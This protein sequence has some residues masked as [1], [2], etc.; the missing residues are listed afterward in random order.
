[1]RRREKKPRHVCRV[2]KKDEDDS[3]YVTS[4][5]RPQT[6][7]YHFFTADRSRGQYDRSFRT[8]GTRARWGS[9]ERCGRA[10]RSYGRCARSCTRWQCGRTDRS[11]GT[12]ARWG[13]REQCGRPGGSCGTRSLCCFWEHASRHFTLHTP[14][15]LT[16]Q[17]T[18][19]P[20][21]RACRTCSTRPRASPCC[22]GNREPCG[23]H[24]R[25]RSTSSALPRYRRALGAHGW[26][27][28][29]TVG[30]IT[31]LV[32]SLMTNVALHLARK[33]R[34]R[35]AHLRCLLKEM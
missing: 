12:R 35:T 13:T 29:L 18:R 1:M 27:E 2:C 16:P 14:F 15:A 20:C 3:R 21:D 5:S 17:G 31:S 32:T 8:C 25:T 10:D 4:L 34:G 26:A 19:R 11:Y 9:H 7:P 23:P 28:A 22:W 24:R 6:T 30:A 33:N